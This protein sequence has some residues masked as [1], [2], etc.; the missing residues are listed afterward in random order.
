MFTF[1]S[2]APY[3]RRHAEPV[4]RISCNLYFDCKY[5]RYVT[6]ISRVTLHYIE[7]KHH[8]NRILFPTLM[9]RTGACANA[10]LLYILTHIKANLS[11]AIWHCATEIHSIAWLFRV[12]CIR[13]YQFTLHYIEKI[14]TAATKI[15]FR[16]SS[17]VWTLPSCIIGHS[18]SQRVRFT[19]SHRPA[20]SAF[21]R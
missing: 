16:H 13:K 11:G 2:H 9:L 5:V 21:N 10:A 18:I 7:N 15:Y 12:G 6:C 8:C 19:S 4:G 17:F 3:G 20:K 1:G 14:N